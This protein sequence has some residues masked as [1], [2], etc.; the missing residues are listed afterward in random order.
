[1]CIASAIRSAV[2]LLLVILFPLLIYAQEVQDE[3][4]FDYVKSS[5]K[6]PEKWGKLHKE[7]SACNKGNMQSPIDLSNKRV[8]VV[9]KSKKLLRNYKPCNAIIVNRGHD[10]EVSWEGYA[11]SIEINGTNY[12]LK[13]AHWH[14]P[15]EHTIN[16]KRY[17]LEL[18]MVHRSTN[19]SSKHQIAVIGVLYKIGKPNPF[20]SK[21][22]RNITSL[23]KRENEHRHHGVIDPREIHMSRRRYYNYI[24]SLTV[25]PCTEGV[26]WTISKKVRTVSLAQ[27]KLLRE[28][29]HDHAEKNARPLQPDHK[30]G[31]QLISP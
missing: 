10:I 28:A 7:W 22:G 14:S 5:G 6:G 26:I 31:I 8:E 17:S 4:E 21:L 12:A 24:G 1:M 2:L 20:L 23:V 9:H 27:V 3:R 16:N 30:R 25:P 19:P 13:Q 15:S 18:H 29:V 11:G